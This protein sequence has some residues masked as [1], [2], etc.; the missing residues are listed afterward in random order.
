MAIRRS[1]RQRHTE[2]AGRGLTVGVVKIGLRKL[3]V[4]GQIALSVMLLIGA[5][6]FLRTLR[7]LQ[8]T[9]L[10]YPRDRI[11]LAGVDFLSAGYSGD[12]LPI[13]YNEVPD[14]L[15][16]IPRVRAVTYSQNGLSSGSESA[17]KITVEG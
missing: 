11:V 7:D 15:A 9:D 12:R 13:V 8:N 14:R 4:M 2:E 5:G 16:R 3:L 6:W 1:Q 17:D 10:G